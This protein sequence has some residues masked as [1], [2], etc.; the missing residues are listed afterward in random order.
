MF[1]CKRCGNEFPDDTEVCPI[2]GTVNKKLHKKNTRFIRALIYIADLLIIVMSFI[3]TVI[4][5]M[6]SHYCMEYEY[7]IFLAREIYWHEYPALI[8]IDIFFIIGFVSTSILSVIARY[9]TN[10]RN[11]AGAKMTVCLF[12][13][14]LLLNVMY[15]IATYFVTAIVTPILSTTIAICSVF[16]CVAVVVSILLLKNKEL[17]F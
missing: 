1:E 11:K 12:A 8:F 6:C 15:P 13:A 9:K 16:F 7:G 17:Y 10:R 4:T 5:L 2:C 14:L 3:S